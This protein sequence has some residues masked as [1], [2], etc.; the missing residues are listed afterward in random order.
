[1]LFTSLVIPLYLILPG[2]LCLPFIPLLPLFRLRGVSVYVSYHVYMEAYK[3]VYFEAYPSWLANTIEW[4]FLYLY[5]LPYVSFAN[6]VGV[7][8]KVADY[9]VYQYAS[10]RS[11]TH[12]YC[13][14]IHFMKSGLDP[15]VFQPSSTSPDPAS[16]LL[17]FVG[18]LAIE[19]NIP[20][21]LKALT[22]PSLSQAQLLI[23][24]D[25][26]ERARLE[27]LAA[28]LVGSDNVYSHP[29]KSSIGVEQVIE[30]AKGKRAVFSGMVYNE[31]DIAR[32][33]GVGDVFVSA[34]AS[35]TFGFTVAEG[36][37]FI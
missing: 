16:P 17:V 37:Q 23:V 1:M 29:A 34:S 32:Y 19:K 20:F 27:S 13:K 2:P 8:S 6:V 9:C 7:P 22:H 5:F 11:L 21:L 36:L 33:Y 28:K 35:E 25:G 18:R 24:G 3:Q 4:L 10:P 12:R 26:P 31:A 14:N 30:I 15:A